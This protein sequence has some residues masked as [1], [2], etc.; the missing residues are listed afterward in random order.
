MLEIAAPL[1]TSQQQLPKPAAFQTVCLEA[2]Q[3]LLE[4]SSAPSPMAVP[5]PPKSPS[6]A[7]LEGMLQRVEQVCASAS[8]W[9]ASGWE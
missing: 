7:H 4:A 5:F 3:T 9:S 1:A 8:A 6:T 2:A